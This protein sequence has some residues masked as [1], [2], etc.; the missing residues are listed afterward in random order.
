[1][2]NPGHGPF[3]VLFKENAEYFLSGLTPRYYGRVMTVVRG[4][5]DDPYPDGQTRVRLPF[6]FSYGSIGCRV[7]GFFITY[8]FADATT[9]RILNI[10]WDNPDYRG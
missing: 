7:S 1:M 5:M 8:E 3:D 2:T 4:L 10:T 6:P 9:I